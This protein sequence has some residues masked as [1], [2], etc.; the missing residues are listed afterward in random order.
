MDADG[1]KTAFQAILN[2]TGKGY[3][4]WGELLTNHTQ[5]V[6]AHPRTLMEQN[7][8]LTAWK[9]DLWEKAHAH[10][11]IELNHHYFTEYAIKLNFNGVKIGTLVAYKGV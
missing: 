4:I 6:E 2:G 3:S 9:K 7:E 10:L 8:F 11:E 1:L 5:I